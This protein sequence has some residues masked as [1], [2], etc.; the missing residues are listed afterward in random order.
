MTTTAQELIDR[1]N[2]FP[3]DL[4][5]ITSADDEGNSYR[6]VDLDWVNVEGYSDVDGE[7]ETGLTELTSQLEE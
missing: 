5:V 3:P 2:T 1:L 7:I 6:Y 4:V